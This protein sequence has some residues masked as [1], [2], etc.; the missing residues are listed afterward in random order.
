[1]SCRMP[2]LFQFQIPTNTTTK[3]ENYEPAESKVQ[4]SISRLHTL[5]VVITRW[6][7][8]F[9]NIYVSVQPAICT[10]LH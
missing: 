10:A 7:E 5:R 4:E 9:A 3:N 8:Q 1:M 6:E 2:L